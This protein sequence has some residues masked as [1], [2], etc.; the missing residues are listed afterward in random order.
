M[1]PVWIFLFVLSTLL[2]FSPI[3][4]F[5]F[6]IIWLKRLILFSLLVFITLVSLIFYTGYKTPLSAPS[7]YIIVLGASVKGETM[8][9]TLLRRT[10]KAFDYLSLHENT[11]AILSG[12][13]GPGEDISEAEAMRRYL[14]SKGIHENRLILEDAST[15]TQENIQ[16]SYK[17]IE[18]A[19]TDDTK[20]TIITS[21]FHILRSRLVALKQGKHAQ[22]IGSKT[23]LYL[24]P[25]YYVREFFGVFVELF[26]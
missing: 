2:S 11:V 14:V 6:G 12:G 5:I 9:L 17:L 25:N 16:F 13:Q 26:R 18:D 8:S 24:A 15:S 22:G 3:Y 1:L 10:Q 19:L 21:H 23:V 4:Q 7:D 20:V